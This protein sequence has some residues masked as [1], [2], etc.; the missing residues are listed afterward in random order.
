[1]VYTVFSAAAIEGLWHRYNE[2][3]LCRTLGIDAVL[4]GV[5]L[6]A[7]AFRALILLMACEV[8]A[9]RYARHPS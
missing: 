7:T 1:M 9:Q 6:L 3:D 5:A 4:L 2:L 8:L